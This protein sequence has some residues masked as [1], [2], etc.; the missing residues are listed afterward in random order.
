MDYSEVL[1][2]AWRIVWK[3]KILWIFGILAGCG[4]GGGGGGG[5]GTRWEQNSPFSQGGTGEMERVM[6]Q[7][8]QWISEHWWVVA[9]GIL[10]L[11]VL[12]AVA[13]FLGTIGK[14]GLIRGTFRVDGGAEK[15]RFAELF[16]ESMPF[17]WRVFLLTFLIGLVFLVVFLPLVLFGIVTAG[18]GF[19]CIIPLLCVLV[20]VL[21]AV[22]IV[23]HQANNA[24]VVEDLHMLDGLKRGWE[25]FKK[26]IGPMLLIWIITGVIGFVI[27][28]VIALPML[29]IVVPTAIGFAT[30]RGELPTAAL[31]VSGLCLVVYLPILIV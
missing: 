3:H 9:L 2:K 25:V 24:I 14:I 26:N 17:F 18:V 22:G 31:L 6:Q 19:L 21:W 28:L 5:S 13:V 23:V 7:A 10:V 20:P 16:R 29:I 12:W 15:V 30:S 27:G 8:G 4:T 1:T 11:L